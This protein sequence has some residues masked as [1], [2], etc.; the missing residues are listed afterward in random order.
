[1]SPLSAAMPVPVIC[2]P[3]R[4]SCP[5]STPPAQ[6]LTGCWQLRGVHERAE[7]VITNA[8]GVHGPAIADHAMGM[9]LAL[10]RQLP[11][12]HEFQEKGEWSRED[13]A[14]RPVALAGKTMLV[15]GIGGIGTE[16]AQRAMALA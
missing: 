5:G 15:V 9:L 8:R 12:Y 6:A 13:P 4:R 16:I 11:H 10:T 7:I 2:W 1:M 3:R 14:Q